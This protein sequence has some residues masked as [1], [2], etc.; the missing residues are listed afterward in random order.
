MNKPK[1]HVA[2]VGMT[3]FIKPGRKDID[4]VDLGTLA[5]QRALRDAGLS[6]QDI[7]AAYAGYVY[8]DSTCGQRVIYQA[9]GCTGIPVVNVN[10]NCSTGAS[11]L[12]LGRQA[13]LAGMAD[14]CLVVGF[15]KM[16]RGSLSSK[17]TDRTDPLDRHMVEM[18]SMRGVSAAPAPPQLFGNAGIEH[19]EKYGT[20][21]RQ[22]ACIASK[23]HNH[24]ANNP[25]SQFRDHYTVDQV[26]ASPK[27][28]GPLTKLQCC[29]TSDGAAACVLMSDKA[30][31][32]YGYDAGGMQ[33]RVANGPNEGSVTYK[34]AQYVSCA[35]RYRD[36]LLLDQAVEIAGMS[37]VTDTPAT[38]TTKS[39]MDVVGRDMTKKAIA[40][41]LAQTGLK[42]G[43]FQVVELHDCFSANELIT[44]EALGLCKEGQ[45]G[46]LNEKGKFTYGSD[47][48]CVINPSGGLISKGHPLGA[49]GL[50][51]C[52]E[53]VWQLRGCADKR[54]VPAVRNALQHN[55]GLG[56]AC[57]VAAYR[58]VTNAP[59]TR[60]LPSDPSVLESWEKEGVNLDSQML[61]LLE[62]PRGSNGGYEQTIKASPCPHWFNVAGQSS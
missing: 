34:Y 5:I 51:Q 13:I 33:F 50:A 26:L 25:Y 14:V 8:G 39:C 58:K 53:L 38:F 20:T 36:E 54:Q 44:T 21:E 35:Y 1:V 32:K 56:G 52:C 45:A 4:Y 24:S 40:G 16:E 49:T 30:A 29:P 46:P 48:I 42:M 18:A 23:N 3:P 22:L 28:F 61:P 59:P 19:M 17:Y 41:V 27:V 62:S 31:R 12:F 9:I 2:G 47:N 6:G 60:A 37:L 11:A 7:E 55:L 43:D 15:E 57:V 10:N